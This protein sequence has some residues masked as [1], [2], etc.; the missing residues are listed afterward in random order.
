MRLNFKFRFCNPYWVL[1]LMLSLIGY[2]SNS[3]D[4][5]ISLTYVEI[6]WNISWGRHQWLI[7]CFDHSEQHHGIYQGMSGGEVFPELGDYLL[8]LWEQ[9]RN[10]RFLQHALSPY[11]YAL[12]LRRD[13]LAS[14]YETANKEGDGSL[15]LLSTTT[16]KLNGFGKG[17]KLCWNSL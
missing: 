15:H 17:L 8:V 7:S 13:F 5:F 3:Q 1:E 6:S 11:A 2:F 4:H 9:R 14:S 10:K 16:M 12:I